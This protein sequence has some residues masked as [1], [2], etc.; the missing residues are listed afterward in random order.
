[1]IFTQTDQYVSNAATED[2][3]EPAQVKK[4]FFSRLFNKKE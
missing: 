2:N 3:T 1:M 4:G